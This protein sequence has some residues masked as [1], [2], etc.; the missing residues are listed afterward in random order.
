MS[1]A[2]H[3]DGLPDLFLDRSLGRHQVPSLLRAEG[4][5]LITLAEHYGVPQDEDVED[6]AWLALVGKRGWV[7]L[8]KDAE[9]RRRPAE[10]QALVEHSVRAF[11]LSGGNLRADEMAMRYIR[12]RCQPWSERASRRQDRSSTQYTPRGSRPSTSIDLASV[13]T[14]TAGAEGVG[15]EPTMGVTHSGFQDRRTR[16]L[17]EP[18]RLTGSL[19][20]TRELSRRRGASS[21]P[22][23]SGPRSRRCGR[24]RP[25]RRC[26]PG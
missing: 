2:L 1:S 5:R 26:C 22:R 9:I 7:A 16:P 6:V 18:S 24:P 20:R 12:A 25:G 10:K 11:C 17:C 8:M 15:F 14:S 3:P 23:A 21:V 13:V 4:L 19:A